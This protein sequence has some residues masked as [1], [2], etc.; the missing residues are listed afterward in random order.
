MSNNC[1]ATSLIEG[2]YVE[3]DEGLFFAVKGI[4]HPEGL[5]I[6]YLRYVPDPRGTRVR[7]SKHYR[8]VYSLD[9]T[10]AYL[11]EHYPQYLNY[12]DEK[13]LTLQSVPFGRISCIYSPRVHLQALMERPESELEETITNFAFFLSEDSQIPITG[14]GVSGS[15]LI[16]MAHSSSDVD[17]I[18]YGIKTGWKVYESLKRLRVDQDWI[19]PYSHENIQEILENRWGDSGL[20]LEKMIDLETRKILHGLVDGRDYFIRLVRKPEETAR[21]ITSRPHGKVKLRA[22]VVDASSSILTPCEYHIEDCTLMGGDNSI[23][24]THLVSYRGKFTEQV[25]EGD[26]VEARGT[27]EGVV[28]EDETIYRLMMGDSEDYLVPTQLIDRYTLVKL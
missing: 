1:G 10:Y 11:S 2:D 8:R 28:Y 23:E 9:E 15:V 21:E 13:E 24:V 4:H 18:V 7:G 26:L 27:L 3:T 19:Q 17:L 6:A 25:V 12:I 20:G 22:K 16:G 5:V 14:I